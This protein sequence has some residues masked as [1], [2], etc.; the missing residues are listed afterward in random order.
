MS[1]HYVILYR[2]YA[3]PKCPTWLLGQ[4][5]ERVSVKEGK[6]F[7]LRISRHRWLDSRTFQA[8]ESKQRFDAILSA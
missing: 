5:K 4:E 1:V 3:A 6:G 8:A 2:V 7:G